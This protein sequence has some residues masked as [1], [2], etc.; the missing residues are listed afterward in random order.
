MLEADVYRVHIRKLK[1]LLGTNYKIETV[2]RSGASYKIT[3]NKSRLFLWAAL[4]VAVIG[5]FLLFSRTWSVKVIGYDDVDA[6]K[7]IVTENGMLG[8]RKNAY[9]RIE[10]VKKAISDFDNEI[11]WN[12][13]TINGSVVEVYIRED[14]SVKVEN[15]GEGDIVSKK[16]CVIRNLIVTSGTAKV[17]NGQTVSEGQV[18]IE[19]SQKFGEEVFSVR[20]EGKAIADV[21]YYGTEEIL[22]EDTVFV[23]TGN[24]I[25]F[26]EVDL[27]GKKIFSRSKS[28]YEHN[29][30]V[31]EEVNT[32]FLPLKINKVTRYEVKPQAQT[33]DKS[34]A[35][36]ETEKEI[37]N[38][39]LLQI[40]ND[41]KVFETK[42]S[43]DEADGILK[44]SVY[45][46]TV[47]DVAITNGN[48]GIIDG[49]S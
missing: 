18:L 14:S 31:K 28:E 11:L 49:T 15:N 7:N 44:I 25:E 43:A 19:A 5:L 6:I 16:D 36:K 46:Q 10:N 2:K 30:D 22:L 24:F 23:E 26:F 34:L 37:I 33:K 41:A 3:A 48:K 12:S 38:K 13:V 20:A 27:F 8:W 32:F 39:L 47:E 17:E 4:S 45:I 21:W 29:K 35:I 1:K 40:P 42:T 9:D